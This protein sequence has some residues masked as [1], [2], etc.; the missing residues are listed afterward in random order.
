[1]TI[2]PKTRI[3]AHAN[4]PIRSINGYQVGFYDVGI[5]RNALAHSGE[6]FYRVGRL[7]ITTNQ[8]EFN[9]VQAIINH[10]SIQYALVDKDKIVI[11][12]VE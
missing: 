3:T 5:L 8:Y 2:T 12:Q 6:D 9:Q 10:P 11:C 4:G 1:M 7:P